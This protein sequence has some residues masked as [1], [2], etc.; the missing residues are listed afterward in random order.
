MTA[1]LTRTLLALLALAA[2]SVIAAGCGLLGRQPQPTPIAPVELALV[3]Y[4]MEGSWSHAEKSLLEQFGA[5]H[6][7]VTFRRAPYLQ[8][9][10][11]YLAQPPSPDL[12]VMTAGYP[13]T[14]A[15]E[16][17]QLVDL[18]DIWEQSG[19]LEQYPAGFQALSAADGKQFFLP[20]GY[21][22]SAIYYN[23]T[24]FDQYGLQPPA[25]WSEFTELCDT[26]LA[27]GITPLSLAG[28]DVWLSGL[29]LDYLDLRLNG[30][31]F[32]RQLLNG[33]ISYTGDRVVSVLELWSWMLQQG[34]FTEHS[35]RLSATD[36]LM[37]VI[38]DQVGVA[39]VDKAAMTLTSPS[40]LGYLPS[41]L[42]QDLDFFPFPV[43]DPSVPPAEVL[44]AYGYMVPVNAEHRDVALAFVEF[45][46]SAEAQS[47]MAQ[48][49]S[50]NAPDLA[51]AH[52]PAE[53]VQLSETTQRGIDIMA[54][55]QDITPL[56]VL[57]V[58]ESMWGRVDTAI[59]RFLRWPDE[60]DAFALALEQARQNAEDAGEFIVPE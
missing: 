29:W 42:L 26:L 10:A 14:R 11:D 46:A 55:A 19:L 50:A 38:T 7:H 57:G 41:T 2:L 6:P 56:Y 5:L 53:G 1:R 3:T 20:I 43:I 44:T 31:D 18:T 16:Q 54:G 47:A 45:V 13:L 30:G 4:D 21:T 40:W 12:M 35:E 27:N 49:I 58:P 37:A 24:V 39:Y 15:V 22:W 9:P 25:T 59:D 51:P 48:Q 52:R 32:H 60:V 8:M 28:S 17:G 23:R 36:S 33:E 34:Y